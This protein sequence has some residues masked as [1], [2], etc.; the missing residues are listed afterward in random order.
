MSIELFIVLCYYI[1]DQR[2]NYILCYFYI[3][4]L[5]IIR[6]K[7]LMEAVQVIN[8]NEKMMPVYNT[9]KSIEKTTKIIDTIGVDEFVKML[10]NTPGIIHS[11]KL[12][13]MVA[14]MDKKLNLNI[15]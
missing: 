6:M 9:T 8:T 5:F 11:S 15:W 12:Q 10:F 14:H 3:H 4:L 13:E 2:I 7:T 1:Y